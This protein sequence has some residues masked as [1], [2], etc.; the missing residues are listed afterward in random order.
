MRLY[1][2]DWRATLRGWDICDIQTL[3]TYCEEELQ[4]RYRKL[5]LNE[6][7]CDTEVEF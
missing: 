7:V 6:K 4:R 1:D 3:I 5:I 2:I